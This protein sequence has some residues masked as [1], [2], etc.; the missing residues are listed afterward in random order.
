MIMYGNIYN[1]STYIYSYLQLPPQVQEPL[2]PVP[3][4]G[5]LLDLRGGGAD[6]AGLLLAAGLADTPDSRGNVSVIRCS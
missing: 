5:L 1:I 4:R 6:S 2:L 3:R